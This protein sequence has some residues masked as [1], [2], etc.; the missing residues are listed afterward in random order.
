[1]SIPWLNDGIGSVD[2]KPESQIVGFDVAIFRDAQRLLAMVLE[3]L[4]EPPELGSDPACLHVA[5]QLVAEGGRSEE[6]ALS[7]LVQFA[8]RLAA[9]I[10]ASHGGDGGESIGSGKRGKGDVGS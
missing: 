4:G 3:I 5:Y 2:G 7:S 1:V 8:P 9:K 10:R 6:L